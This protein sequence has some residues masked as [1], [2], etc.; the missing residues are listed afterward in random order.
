MKW[1][2]AKVLNLVNFICLLGATMEL[3]IRY[4]GLPAQIISR[5]SLDGSLGEPGKKS[6]LLVLALMMWALTLF[7]LL[8]DLFPRL[9]RMQQGLS[10][11]ETDVGRIVGQTLSGIKLAVTLLLWWMLH[12]ALGQQPLGRAYLFL[13]L[14]AITLPLVLM[15]VRILRIK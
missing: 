6:T 5:Y 14:L 11:E 3:A 2:L 7:L 8:A 1:S 15:L 12:R 4:G 13:F 10:S 9:F